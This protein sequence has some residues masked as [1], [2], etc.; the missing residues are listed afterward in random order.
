MRRQAGTIFVHKGW[1]KYNATQL[2]QLL[3]VVDVV[4]SFI[5]KPGSKSYPDSYSFV[6]NR[7]LITGC[8]MRAC[9][10]T[11]TPRTWTRWWRN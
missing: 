11:R 6:S 8:I 7:F 9:R 4:V 3:A 2:A 1:A 5:S 10:W